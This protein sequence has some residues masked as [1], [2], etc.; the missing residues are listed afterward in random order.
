MVG[1]AGVGVCATFRSEE[2]AHTMGLRLILAGGTA[3][4]AILS[5]TAQADGQEALSQPSP[6][7]QTQAAQPTSTNLGEVIVTA[8]RRA[9]SIQSVPFEIQAI[10]SNGLKAQNI[11]NFQ[12]YVT[13]L[14]GVSFAG[15]GPGQNDIYIRGLASNKIG[16]QLSGAQGTA[17]NVAL[18][19]DDQPVTLTG[20]NL[21]VYITDMERI[22]VL[23]GPQGTLFGASSQAGTVRLITKKPELDKW[24]V[25]ITA[26][27]SGTH[28]GDPSESVEGFLNVPL[29][30]GLAALRIAAYDSH[31]G[32]YIDNVHGTQTLS[33]YNPFYPGGGATYD[34]ADNR[35]LVKND[36]NTDTYRGVRTGL[37]VTPTRDLTVLFQYSHQDLTTDAVF[38][39]D[40][41]VAHLEV[42]RYFPDHLD[43][44]YDQFSWNVEGK[45]GPLDAIYTGGFLHRTVEQTMDYTSYGNVGPFIPYY[46]CNAK[47]THC[48]DPTLG[49]IGH[50]NSQRWNHEAR[51]ST[52]ANWRLRFTAGAFYDNSK[53][54]DQGDF[55]YPSS[56]LTGFVQNSPIPGSTESNPNLRAPGIT[57][58]N[59]YTNR[60]HELSFFGEGSFDV[61]P[62]LLTLTAGLRR[63]HLVYSLAGSTSFGNRFG[64]GLFGH[65]IDELLEGVS[66]KTEEGVVPRVTVTLKPLP[67]LLFYATYSQGFRPG[68]FNRGYDPNPD[69][70]DHVIPEAYVSDKVIN[71]EAGWKTTLFHGL[72]RWN[73]TGYIMDWNNMQLTTQNVNI[74]QLFYTYNAANSTI[75]GLESDFTI[76]PDK[77]WEFNG[78]VTYNDTRLTAILGN[79][80]L[81]SDV[82]PVGSRLAQAP[83]FQSN[84]RARYKWT[85]AGNNLYV[86]AGAQGSSDSYS[87]LDREERQ[88]QAGYGVLN[89]SA[90]LSRDKWSATLYADNVTDTRADLY[91]NS[92]YSPRDASG[93]AIVSQYDLITTN[94]PL[95]VGVKFSVEMQ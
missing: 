36:F 70:T 68:G 27:V 63:Y 31:D 54:T 46:V 16:V 11:K 73:G 5:T 49:Y 7:T 33:P 79:S 72:V 95:T 53:T 15:T 69:K 85:L 74:A 62:D 10:D 19:L 25:G 21:D 67:R 47:Y 34:A 66:P 58:I 52:P 84:V 18:Y 94:R 40:P 30:P 23:A 45:L 20:R 8:T 60:G 51:L 17:P 65:N 77:H 2:G 90:G 39:H 43:D 82:V 55:D 71:Y 91:N 3:L 29:V 48:Y 13:H 56:T 92:H 44:K 81:A 78:A 93:N 42:Q 28:H 38:A 57:F 86:E 50:V 35:N 1:R 76:A 87:S 26:G 83:V 9:G 88:R 80:V 64:P 24:D 89:L 75:K 6:A 14:P 4:A 37:K 22:E 41:D 32:G 12:D 61:L 59:D